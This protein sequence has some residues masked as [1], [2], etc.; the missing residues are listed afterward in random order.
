MTITSFLACRE[1]WGVKIFQAVSPLPEKPSVLGVSETW[2]A[3]VKGAVHNQAAL[4]PVCQQ[5]PPCLGQQWAPRSQTR[6]AVPC[7]VWWGSCQSLTD[8]QG[9]C[10]HVLGHWKAEKKC[11]TGE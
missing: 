5:H 3:G 6:G 8:L 9:L 1:S 4:S 2:A 11:K 7:G 10:S